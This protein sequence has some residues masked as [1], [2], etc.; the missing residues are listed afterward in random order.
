MSE[1]KKYIEVIANADKKKPTIDYDR[2]STRKLSK[3]LPEGWLKSCLAVYWLIHEHDKSFKKGEDEKISDALRH[4]EDALDM[5]IVWNKLDR[6]M[7]RS[8]LHSIIMQMKNVTPGKRIQYLVALWG[9]HIDKRR[10]IALDVL[11]ESIVGVLYK[12]GHRR[13]WELVACALMEQGLWNP[14]T[15]NQGEALRQRHLRIVKAGHA[16]AVL[17]AILHMQ[18]GQGQA[19]ST[20]I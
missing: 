2:P 7:K 15:D 1:L 3:V 11:I 6:D 16:E 19:N 18:V 5:L 9:K 14:D 17:D 4:I 12:T 13:F 8:L 20:A 10:D